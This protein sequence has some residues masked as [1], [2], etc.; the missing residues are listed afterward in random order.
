[1]RAWP[2]GGR[3]RAGRLGHWRMG[4]NGLRGR[5]GQ[6][7]GTGALG[8][9]EEGVYLSLFDFKRFPNPFPKDFEIIFSFDQIHTIKKINAAAWMHQH[10]ASLIVAFNLIKIINFLGLNAH[11]MHN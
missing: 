7:R 8:Q 3:G 11:T 9:K 1:M 4:W 2:R 6:E 10:V 5:V